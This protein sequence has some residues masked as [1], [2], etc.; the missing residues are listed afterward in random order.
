MTGRDESSGRVWMWDAQHLQA[1]EVALVVQVESGSFEILVARVAADAS[2]DEVLNPFFGD[3]DPCDFWATLTACDGE[4]AFKYD[5]R[6]PKP[7]SAVTRFCRGLALPVDWERHPERE[8]DSLERVR[9]IAAQHYSDPFGPD[10]E[11]NDDP[12]ESDPVEAL[13]P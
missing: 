2:I 7:N 8:A 1:I 9:Q 3:D 5:R 4:I 10:V 12:W 6:A 13:W 11:G